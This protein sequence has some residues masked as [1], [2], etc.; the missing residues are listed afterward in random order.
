MPWC[1][2][3][4]V[5]HYWEGCDKHLH[6]PH[7]LCHHL[8]HCLLRRFEALEVLWFPQPHHCYLAGVEEVQQ[9]QFHQKWTE[10]NPVLVHSFC[11]QDT[12]VG[13]SRS[14][15]EWYLNE[16]LPQLKTSHDF[17]TLTLVLM[18]WQTKTIVYWP[19]LERTY[20]WDCIEGSTK[21]VWRSNWYISSSTP[22]QIHQERV[23]S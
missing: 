8:P 10:W 11:L 15:L 13:D 6:P 16:K 12:A 22:N 4:G 18:N 19:P 1:D 5:S 7:H 3:W 2:P 14:N 20:P 23:R 21:I 9:L 17:I